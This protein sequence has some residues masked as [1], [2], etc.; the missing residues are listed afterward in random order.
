MFR[1]VAIE[2]RKKRWSGKVILLP[3]I[4]PWLI[5]AFSVFFLIIFLLFI[6]FGSYTRRVNVTGEITTYPRPVNIYSSVQ[7]FVVKRFVSEGQMVKKGQEIYQI[8][9]S[10]STLS[11]VVS[12]NQKKN[13][14][15]QLIKIDKM[16]VTLKENKQTT[17]ETLEKQ[18]E[19]YTE[20][21]KHAS[22]II[23]RAEEGVKIAK[24]NMENYK[25]YQTR[26]LINK[27]QLTINTVFKYL[28]FYHAA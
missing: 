25:S 16:I 15:N 2:S 26:G 13:I 28:Y 11:G 18:K 17:L 12:D 4:S 21:F 24:N 14:T 7:G 20:A 23:K 3:G 9:V 27:D 6:S 5:S 22:E 8:D 19:Q 1:Q 10:R